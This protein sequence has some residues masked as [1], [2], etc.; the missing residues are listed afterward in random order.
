MEKKKKLNIFEKYLTLWVLLCI[1]AG[2]LIGKLVP[3]IAVALDSLS[4]Y[5]VSIPIAFCLFFMMYPIMV[6]IDFR[7]VIKA[8]KTPKPGGRTFRSPASTGSQAPAR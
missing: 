8:G 4:V 2:I 6:K 1:G 3:Q 5:Q 7:E